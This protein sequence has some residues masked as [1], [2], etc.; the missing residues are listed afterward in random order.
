M[1]QDLLEEEKVNIK[2]IME[3]FKQIF[4]PLIGY[5]VG[6]I[7]VL[8]MV[9]GCTQMSDSGGDVAELHAKHETSQSVDGREDVEQD[10][11]EQIDENGSY[12]SRDEVARYIATYKRLPSNFIT[13]NE[14]K[15]LG[16]DKSENYVSDVA[17]G[18][19]IGGDRFGNFEKQLPF[20]KGRVYRECDI[21]YTGG[22]RG[23]KRIIFS[24]DGLIYYTKDHYKTFENLYGEE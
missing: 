3:K 10:S 15:E 17:E 23:A 21:D 9:T 14:A 19:S 4:S 18:K 2:L 8:T 16:W 11:S 7:V 13:K 24:N 20:K 5:V 6:L 12:T 1:V 22:K